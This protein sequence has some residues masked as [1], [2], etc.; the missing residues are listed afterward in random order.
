MEK[1]L[2]SEGS[3]ALAQLQRAVSASFLEVFKATDGVLGSLN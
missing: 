1:I 3:E 2:Y